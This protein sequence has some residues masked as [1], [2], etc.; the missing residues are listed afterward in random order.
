[1][2]K[3]HIFYCLHFKRYHYIAKT[4]DPV[5]CAR[6]FDPDLAAGAAAGAGVSSAAAGAASFSDFLLF[7]FFS[8]TSS[9]FQCLNKKNLLKSFPIMNSER[10]TV[11]LKQQFFDKN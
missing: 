2:L 8:F 9:P 1:V 7:F 5:L 4:L 3:Y 6:F 11:H 10:I